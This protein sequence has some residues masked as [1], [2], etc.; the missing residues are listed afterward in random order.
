MYI[1]IITKMQSLSIFHHLLLLLF[2]LDQ[3]TGQSAGLAG[4]EIEEPDNEADWPK[5]QDWILAIESISKLSCPLTKNYQCA[6]PSST[7]IQLTSATACSN[8]CP[9]Q[10]S[11]SFSEAEGTACQWED[12]RK[13]CTQCTEHK[14]IHSNNVNHYA[15]VCLPNMDF[16]YSSNLW[17][18]SEMD[19]TD[20]RSTTSGDTEELHP[21]TTGGNKLHKSYADRTFG[22]TKEKKK[23][24]R[25]NRLLIN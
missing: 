13:I 8:W 16:S 5:P 22:G 11:A 3:T 23:K 24:R 6:Q 25:K 7:P 2:I 20:V 9:T 12:D 15:G 10:T 17:H 4:L 1:C 21:D 18:A 19:F 14:L